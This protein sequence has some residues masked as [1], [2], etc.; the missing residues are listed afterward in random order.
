M[1]P[2]AT[3]RRHGG[4]ASCPRLMVS[5]SSAEQPSPARPKTRDAEPRRVVGQV[6]DQRRTCRPARRAAAWKTDARGQPAD[7]GREQHPA[8][9]DHG[10]ERGQRQRGLGRR[11]A[12]LRGHVL[13]RPVAV[14]RLADPVEDG[15][16]GEQ[17]EPRRDARAARRHAPQRRARLGRAAAG[18]AGCEQ[19]ADEQHRGQDRQAPPEAEPDED[20]DEH[21]RQ[22]G[23]EP[24][25]GVEHQDRAVGAVGLERRDVGVQHR[26]RQPEAGARG[27]RWPP[28]AAGRRPPGRPR[29]RCVTTSSTIDVMFAARPE[30]Q[31]ALRAEPARQA[32]PEQGRRDGG[33]APGAGTWRRTGCCSGRT[34]RVGEDRAGRGEGDQRDALDQP[35]QVD[36]PVLGRATPSSVARGLRPVS[37]AAPAG[38]P[39]RA[40]RWPW[41]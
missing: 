5:G 26:H 7:D 16:A 23:P 15:E 34:G 38:G 36:D 37:R 29:R 20:G 21:R 32:G 10:P 35:G 2:P 33:H 39:R 11:G 41:R 19:R 4:S 12:E 6:G 9:G 28:A 22:G 25:Q 8:D 27:T 3:R 24:E 31:H 18:R 14:H 30:E 17:P 40:A 1:T 13:L